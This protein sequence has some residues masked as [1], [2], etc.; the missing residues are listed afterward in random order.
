MTF[1]ATR[2]W[3][4]LTTL[5]RSRPD[6]VALHDDAALDVLAHDEVRAAVLLT[7]WRRPT[8]ESAADPASG[9]ASS[10]TSIE[11]AVDSSVA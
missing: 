6:D 3:M 11:V 2:A 1:C 9:S 10:P 8:A 4:S 7:A 5:R